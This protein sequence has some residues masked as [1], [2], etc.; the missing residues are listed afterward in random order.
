MKQPSSL[1]L[2]HSSLPRRGFTLFELLGVLTLIGVVLAVL[3]GA[4]GSW[5]TV[6]AVDGSVRILE[7]GLQQARTLARSRRMYVGFEY[8]TLST[9]DS[10]SVSGFQLYL[11]TNDNA[12]V[13]AILQEH[14]NNTPITNGERE[15]MGMSPAAPH[16][17]LSGHIRLANQSESGAR[18]DES[19]LFFNPDGSVWSWDDQ[20]SHD[21]YVS[22]REL[23]N[24][25][26]LARLLRVEL[27]TGLVTVIKPEVTP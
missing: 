23:F 25:A 5:G 12:T 20:H 9:N 27:D 7:A 16:Q 21:L 19:S 3:L 17:R 22:S 2:H 26:P 24:K 8:G 18:T 4:Y 13:A 15:D 10:R 11:C 6:H 14:Q 1:I